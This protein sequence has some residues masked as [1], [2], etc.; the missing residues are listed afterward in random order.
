MPSI[1]DKIRNLE[2]DK[3]GVVVVEL[4]NG[5]SVHKAWHSNGEPYLEAYKLDGQLH[6][7]ET[8][9][10]MYGNILSKITWMYG[11]MTIYEGYMHKRL[12]ERK[13][14]DDKEQL[15]LLEIWDETG[16]QIKKDLYDAGV[17]I[18]TLL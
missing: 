6:G 12:I 1:L 2:K 16:H 3:K 9:W 4:G 5:Y 15:I 7:T 13:E 10:N 8:I 14:F 18:G 17:R 11:K